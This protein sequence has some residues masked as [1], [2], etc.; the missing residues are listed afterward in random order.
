[1]LSC[2]NGESDSSVNNL[3]DFAKEFVSTHMDSYNSMN[4]DNETRFSQLIQNALNS[5]ML[6]MVV[7][8]LNHLIEK[9]MTMKFRQSLV[10]RQR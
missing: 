4:M 8:Y 9:R 5:M 6:M 10:L 3:S 1:M 7:W 2:D